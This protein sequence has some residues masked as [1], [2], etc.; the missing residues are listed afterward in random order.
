MQAEFEALDPEVLSATTTRF[1]KSVMQ[2][3]KG[4]PP[5]NVVPTL[6]EK[7]ENMKNKVSRQILQAHCWFLN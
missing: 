1:F 7:V 4:L 2:L 5:N 3:E 6:K